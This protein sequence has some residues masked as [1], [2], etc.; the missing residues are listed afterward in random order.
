[1]QKTSK[2]YIK[3]LIIN[4]FIFIKGNAL[5][6]MAAKGSATARIKYEIVKYSDFSQNK[7]DRMK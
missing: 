4:K 1:M 7:K 2:E 6:I 3:R 5:P